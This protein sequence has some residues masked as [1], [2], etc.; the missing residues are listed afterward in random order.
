MKPGILSQQKSGSYTPP[1]IP[2]RVVSSSV[3]T[4]SKESSPII[5][6]IQ[7]IKF[8]IPCIFGFAPWCWR[9]KQTPPVIQFA[10][11]AFK[12]K[13]LHIYLL[14]GV[15]EGEVS[16]RFLNDST[17]GETYYENE[18]TGKTTE[19]QPDE[20]SATLDE[21]LEEAVY[22]KNVG[23]VLAEIQ[24]SVNNLRPKTEVGADTHFKRTGLLSTIHAILDVL[25][26]GTVYVN[27]S[28]N[29]TAS[30]TWAGKRHVIEKEFRYE[31][32]LPV[33]KVSWHLW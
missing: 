33:G 1:E 15:V 29:M 10:A 20:R 11:N 9:R 18:V 7:I 32:Y 22:L 25:L 26:K 17:P 23:V 16:T 27:D 2:Y 6:P 12:V 14:T 30:Y 8:I 31:A 3:K 21:D 24:R 13:D 28:I 4:V 19:P 5:E